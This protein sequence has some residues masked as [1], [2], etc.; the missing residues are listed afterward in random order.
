MLIRGSIFRF[1]SAFRRKKVKITKQTHFE[2]IA[3]YS[4]VVYSVESPL[5]VEI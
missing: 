1:K 5:F 4:G 2:R 3:V